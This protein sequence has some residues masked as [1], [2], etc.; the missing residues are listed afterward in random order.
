VLSD[1]Q[2]KVNGKKGF[3]FALLIS[4]GLFF[5][6]SLIG[7]AML[8]VTYSSSRLIIDN[9][10]S[11]LGKQV[12]TVSELIL[13]KNLS[14][15]GKIVGV[16]AD[17]LPVTDMSRTHQITEWLYGA[18]FSQKE[19]AMDF[20]AYISADEQNITEVDTELF[21][22]PGIRKN[23][24]ANLQKNQS[25]NW[26]YEPATGT[27]PSNVLIYYKRETLNKLTGK[28]EGYLVGGVFLRDNVP[29]I[30]EIQERTGAIFTSLLWSDEALVSV[31]NS[32]GRK[33]S[34]MEK[35]DAGS[36]SDDLEY[37][38]ASAFG[39]LFPD[40][41]L[42]VL[43][44][45]PS[46]AITSLSDLYLFSAAIGLVLIVAFSAASVWVG[47][48]VFVSP[49]SRLISY[50]Q[51]VERREFNPKPP[52]SPVMEFNEVARNLQSVFSAFQESERRFE[53][54]VSISSDSVWETDEEHRYTYISH[55]KSALD[56][57]VGSQLIGTRR[58]E[59]NGVGQDEELWAEHKRIVMAREPFRNFVFL[60]R[61]QKGEDFYFSSSGRPKY[62]REGV[63]LGYR[64]ASTDIT[65]EVEM[66]RETEDYQNQLRQSQK[67]E[68]VGQLT[69]GIA[70]D[71][72]NLL[73]VVIGNLELVLE[74]KKLMDSQ[75]KMLGDAMRGAEKGAR[76]T[77]QL[78][79]YSRQQ[80][81][82]PKLVRPCDVISDMDTLLKRAVGE[83]I[84]LTA[85]F[86]DSWGILIDPSELENAL[87]NLVV[88]ARDAIDGGGRISIESF[89]IQI[90]P[91]YA[92]MKLD[93]EPGD[94]VC[95]I[96]SDNGSGMDADIQER[97]FEPFFTTKEVGKGSGL[98][99][100]MVFGFAKQSGG[101]VSIYSEADKGTSIK[102]FLPRAEGEIKAETNSDA[103]KH[104]IKLGNGE[105]I[106]VIE[107]NLEFRELV[108]LQL[109]SIGYV[110]VE[111]EDGPSALEILKSEKIDVILS[112]IILPGGMSGVDILKQTSLK[113]PSICKVLMSG[114]TGNSFNGSRELPAGVDVLFKPFTK[115][116]LSEA[117]IAAHSNS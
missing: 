100:S 49:L 72:N 58:W 99:L 51:A 69:G 24:L 35:V 97:V 113:Y 3:R 8:V 43:T 31:A 12:E 33:F 86:E 114:F 59:T 60:W 4:G 94:Y 66:Q 42:S 56:T 15:L 21:N 83:S 116:K 111:C 1:T 39:D 81:L 62:N 92:N 112:D 91:D 29:L 50:A 95:V 76:L 70:H 11:Q 107:D 96:V 68:V 14:L 38:T 55:D 47:R 18:Y 30:E 79:A 73:S 115:I 93:L 80:A 7:V 46:G 108:V 57:V 85:Q 101:Y 19:G 71:F 36:L 103:A 6:L 77:H 61:N 88:N 37:F 110:T 67:L 117:I 90:D 89:N 16:L 26:A 82:S 44:I 34:D 78:L 84:E 102:L 25:W 20:L 27:V 22:F 28:V 53:D 65:A 40:A 5:L 23:I 41:R 104:V 10:K 105:R 17:E 75:K 13:E 64:G 54:F 106:L 109:K 87:M 48:A 45:I 32:Q 98:G 63:F 9:E 2:S 52:V 74:D